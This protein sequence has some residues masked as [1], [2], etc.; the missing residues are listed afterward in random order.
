MSA[1]Q[2][3]QTDF[4]R[5]AKQPLSMLFLARKSLKHGLAFIFLTAIYAGQSAVK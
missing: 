2:F 4:S 1:T 3:Y 5:N